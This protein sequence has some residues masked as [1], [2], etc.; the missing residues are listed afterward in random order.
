MFISI[1]DQ[2][3]RIV[4]LPQRPLRI[5][6]LVPSQTELLVD[7]GLEDHLVGITRFC[8]YPAGLIDK[9]KVV[10]GTKKVIASRIWEVKPDL[11]ICNKE[12]NTQEIV[13]ACQEIAPTYVSDIANLDDAMEMITDLGKMTGTSFKAKSLVNRIKINFNHFE[14]ESHSA[15]NALY[16]IWKDP[17]M[18]VGSDTFIHDIMERGGYKNMM[19]GASRYPELTLQ[20]IVNLNPQVI[21]LSSEPYAFNDLDKKEFE[22][23]FAKAGLKSPQLLHVDGTYFSWYGSRLK[24][25]VDYIRELRSK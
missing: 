25:T 7:L 9:I 19:D 12:E 6:S 8:E 2:C 22:D 23:A 4:E 24:N 11:I 1:T 5:V 21:M 15:I 16:L 14:K 13:L 18:T 20:N 17:Y 3:Y 10:G